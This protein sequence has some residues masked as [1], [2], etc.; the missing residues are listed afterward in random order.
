MSTPIA[1]REIR[2]PLSAADPDTFTGTAWSALLGS[3][4]DRAALRLFY[5]EFAPG[6]RT[7][8]HSHSGTQILLVQ[9]GLCLVGR[10]GEG[11]ERLGP[12]GVVSIAPGELHWH[13][14]APGEATAHFAI[15]LANHETRWLGPVTDDEAGPAPSA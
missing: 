9:Q 12:G 5:V 13:G 10:Q 6:A 14:A 1:S 11:V 15:N 8:W 4:A 2:W 3:A 7:H